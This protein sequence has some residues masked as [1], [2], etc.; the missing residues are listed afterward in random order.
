LEKLCGEIGKTFEGNC[1][2]RESDEDDNKGV[3]SRDRKDRS[4]S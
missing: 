1:F 4:G 3:G 2:Q